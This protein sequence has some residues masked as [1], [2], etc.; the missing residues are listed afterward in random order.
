MQTAERIKSA[1]EFVSTNPKKVSELTDFL[2]TSD[3]PS[4]GFVDAI[5]RIEFLRLHIYS[6]AA[7]MLDK[8]VL[9]KNNDV[10]K[11]LI[12]LSKSTSIL[13]LFSSNTMSL[14]VCNLFKDEF[15]DRTMIN[16]IIEFS[17]KHR[18]DDKTDTG[19]KEGIPG[20][21]KI[22]TGD[23]HKITSDEKVI[24]AESAVGELSAYFSRKSEHK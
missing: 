7:S 13:A 22:N 8:E 14:E 10:L 21:Q 12:E 11:K 6:Y 16:K 18:G 3:D 17:Q 24:T 2:M 19:E 9:E 20:D 4:F 5:A 15:K 23:G 1:V